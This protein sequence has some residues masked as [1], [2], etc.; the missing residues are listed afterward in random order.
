MLA[1][2]LDACVAHCKIVITY[3]GLLQYLGWV[4]GFFCFWFFCVLFCFLIQDVATLQRDMSNSSHR[5]FSQGCNLCLI[6]NHFEAVSSV[7]PGCCFCLRF[8]F[9]IFFCSCSLWHHHHYYFFFLSPVVFS[10]FLVCFSQASRAQ[11]EKLAAEWQ[12]T[13]RAVCIF[14]ERVRRTDNAWYKGMFPSTE[15]QNTM[16]I[17]RHLFLQEASKSYFNASKYACITKP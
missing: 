9:L 10:M 2:M 11:P 14:R 4:W 3:L 1:C 5:F 13:S 6:S 15:W 17:E 7:L 8:S 16:P 12:M